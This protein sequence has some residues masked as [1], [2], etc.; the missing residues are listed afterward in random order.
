LKTAIQVRNKFKTYNTITEA[1]HNL[2]LKGYTFDFSLLTDKDCIYCNNLNQSL[3]ADEFVID[4]VH[5]FE[6][7][8]DPGDEMILYAISSTKYNLKGVLLNAYGVYSDSKNSKIVEK[9]NYQI[10]NEIKPIKRS[11]ELVQ[12][13][14]EH[15]HGL[16]LCWKIRTGIAKKIEASRI[17]NYVN[18]FY[19]THLLPHFEIEEKYIFPL[20]EEKNANR[21]IAIQQHN[22]IRIIAENKLIDYNELNQL[23][24]LLNEH[25]RFEE[26]VLFNEI[27]NLGLLNNLIVLEKLN[28]DRKFYENESDPFWK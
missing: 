20:L 1:L 9:L 17:K 21:N 2:N 23:Q 8:T 5:R 3:S 7:E 14:R 10:K 18:W 11:K 16:L 26:R 12:L 24:K 28:D 25:I 6:G 4:E 19:N 13:S 22:E 15:H 27:Q